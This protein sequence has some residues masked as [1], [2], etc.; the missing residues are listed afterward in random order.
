MS[1][2]SFY[3]V[4]FTVKRLNTTSDTA[5]DNYI[6]IGTFRG[7]IRPVNDI[8]QLY[9]AGAQGLEFNL[10]CDETVDILP[11]DLITIS[12]EDYGVIGVQEYE[13]IEF[14]VDTHKKIR[15]SRR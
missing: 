14:N 13:D 6:T 4:D 15:I 2:S 5:L 1:L 7:V 3:N 12:D 8:T 11:N 9:N 10:Y